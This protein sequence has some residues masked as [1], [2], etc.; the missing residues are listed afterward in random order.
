MLVL[1]YKELSKDGEEEVITFY[2]WTPD[3]I[4]RLK[5]IIPTRDIISL[6]NKVKELAESY[7]EVCAQNIDDIK[8]PKLKNML[9]GFLKKRIMQL[10]MINI[11]L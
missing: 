1:K 8:T 3:T 11:K 10:F 6:I 2:E 9:R 7:G 4:G 5:P